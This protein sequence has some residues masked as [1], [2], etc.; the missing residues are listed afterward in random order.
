M[1]QAGMDAC[2]INMSHST[3]EQ[4][5]EL[6]QTVRRVAAELERPIGVGADLKGPKLRIGEIAGGS[7]HIEDGASFRLEVGER[8]GD[9]GVASVDYPYLLDDLRPGDAVLL[10]DGAL[11]LRVEEIEAG[12][13][14]CRVEKGGT[15]SSR[16]G[17]NF[18]GIAL[19]TP[20]LTEKDL[21]DM[22]TALAVGVDFLYLSY[23][24]SAQHVDAVKS[25]LW[26]RGADLP[27]VAK[28][29]RQEG[30]EAL[31]EIVEAADGVCVAR[32]DLGIEMPLGAVP[33]LQEEAGRLCRLGARLSLVGGQVLSSMVGNPIPLRAEVA[34]VAA[35]VRDGLDGIILSDETSVGA[36][37]VGTVAACARMLERAEERWAAVGERRWAAIVS[38]DGRAA[39]ALASGRQFQ[40][41]VAVVDEARV[42]NW[43]AGWWGVVPVTRG[44]GQ[45][46]AA[47]ALESLRARSADRDFV[48]LTEADV[49]R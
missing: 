41:V 34:D 6:V 25:A 9:S 11:A 19:R 14:R 37:P 5:R 38:P 30:A 8:L 35:A 22:R 39:A 4:T 47:L 42:A 1:A 3:P 16:K 36:Y 23:A 43:L 48:L 44:P 26:D 21:L 46:A 33:A 32:G 10:S 31:R 49:Y 40:G 28:V 20:S 45:N 24:R 15:L 12:A 2:R 27:V 29:E 7:V 18:P 17:V 13:V